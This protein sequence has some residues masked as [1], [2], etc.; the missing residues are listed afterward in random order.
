MP[1][2]FAEMRTLREEGKVHQKL[3]TRVR[4]LLVI[5]LILLLI[6][7]YNLIMRPADAFTALALCAVGFLLGLFVFSRMNVVEW[8]E[9]ESIVQT[10]RMDAVGFAV[11]ALYI[12]FEIS[13]RTFL[14]DFFPLSVTTL[15]LAGIFGTIFGRAVGTVIEIHR[16]YKTS[17][18]I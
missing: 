8:N 5:A 6:S 9:A 15:L 13:L 16:V 10:G 7:A 3:L 11:I 1:N 12:V 18:S 4:L 14:K 17:H 2:F